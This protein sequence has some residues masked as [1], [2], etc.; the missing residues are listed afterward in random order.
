[1]ATLAQTEA[2]MT[3]ESPLGRVTAYP[4]QYSPGLLYA[5]P[6]T[7]GRAALGLADEPPFHGVDLWNVWELTWLDAQGLPKT[8]TAEIS[9]PAE[10]LNIVESKSL[11]LYL[12][13]FAMSEFSAAADVAATIERD[14]SACAGTDVS[15]RIRRPL[16]THGSSIARLAGH[17]LD[18]LSASCD[19]YEVDPGLL[20]ADADDIVSEDLYSHL[21]RS[22]CPVTSQPD[23]GSVMISYRGPRIDREALLRYIVSYRQHNDFH[24]ACV[25]RM[26]VDIL[27]RCGAERL[28]VYARYQRRG[29]IDINP[30]RSNFEANPPNTRLWRQ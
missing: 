17:C 15:V 22:L 30:F 6:R 5:I 3:R 23:N 14:L 7:E 12:G 29:G 1:L 20:C 28:T 11:K 19:A 25:E 9:I 13:S 8:A 24:E 26:F 21:L 27:T 2:E 16:S 18:T 10:S 4:E